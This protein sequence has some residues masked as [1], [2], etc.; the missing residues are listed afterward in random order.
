M[1]QCT[2]VSFVAVWALCAS[3]HAQLRVATYNTNGGPR[4][5]SG[6]VLAELAQESVRGIARPLDVLLLQE[7]NSLT[8]TTDG[9]LNLLNQMGVGTYARGQVVAGT[10][11]GGRVALIYNRDT[12]ALIDERTIGQACTCGAARQ[13]MRYQLRPVG[14]GPDADFFAYVSHYKASTGSTNVSRRLVEATAIRADADSLPAGVNIIY[15]GDFNMRSSSEA[16]FQHLLSAGNGQ[17]FDP[18]DRLGN[19]HNNIGFI[20]LHTQSPVTSARFPG[21]VPGGMDDRFDLQLTSGALLDGEGLD[22]ISGSYHAFGNNGTHNW[23]NAN[24]ELDVPSNTALPQ[25]VLTAIAN[26][27][28]HLPVVMDLQVP[29]VMQVQVTAVPDTVDVG[30]QVSFTVTVENVADVVS[31]LGADELDYLLSTSGDLSGAA[32]DFELALGGGNQH[33]VTLNTSTAGIKQGVLTVTGT[34]AAAANSHVTIPI[35]YEVVVAFLR[36]DANGDS[37]VSGLDLIAVQEGFG[38]R[39]DSDP[40]MVCL[41]D[42]DDDGQVSGLDLI[43]V[44]ENF[45]SAVAAPI[46]ESSTLAALSWACVLSARRRG[47]EFHR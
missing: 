26:V 16:A 47:G 5:D 35:S 31:A 20:D 15:A 24:G 22:Y 30:S 10:N 34:S 14:Y 27:S 13:P 46:P 36:G 32:A 42:A 45:G 1:K 43:A 9:F 38:D 8:G 41:G 11:G 44:Q 18:I 37:M 23:N 4:A 39:C 25:N 33:L 6:T 2:F 3:V 19:W 28:D 40:Q 21:Q 7:Q 17:A 12:V 29:A